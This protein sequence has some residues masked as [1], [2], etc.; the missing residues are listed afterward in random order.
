VGR[1]RGGTVETIFGAREGPRF[2]GRVACGG[3]PPPP[4]PLPPQAGEGEN[5]NGDYDGNCNY[6]N[7]G[8]CVIGVVGEGSVRFGWLRGALT[9]LAEARPPSP[10][11]GRGYGAGDGAGF[12]AFGRA[13]TS[14]CHADL[15][16]AQQFAGRERS[17]SQG[18]LGEGQARNEPG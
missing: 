17:L 12:G 9:R 2:D 16:R 4:G 5:G 6:N 15:E 10:N 13:S 14:Y 11:F 3:G 1:K 8:N 18:F 7:N